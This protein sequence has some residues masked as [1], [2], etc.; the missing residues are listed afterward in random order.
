MDPTAIVS[1]GGS[2][3]GT[4]IG[5][6]TEANVQPSE[7][8]VNAIT[9]TVALVLIYLLAYSHLLTAS[10]LGN[11]ELERALVAAVVPLGV[12]FAVVIVYSALPY[13]QL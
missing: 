10:D 4:L 11:R 6:S 9:L 7:V 12:V 3:V 13:V 1:G 8:G 2:V 5:V